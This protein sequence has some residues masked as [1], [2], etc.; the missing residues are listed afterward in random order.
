LYF[1]S[2]QSQHHINA[3]DQSSSCTCLNHGAVSF[4]CLLASYT[5]EVNDF[6]D[7]PMWTGGS[8]ALV[9]KHSLSEELKLLHPWAYDGRG[10][11]TPEMPIR[12]LPFW[13]V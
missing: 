6:L 11:L 7:V 1:P 4:E 10:L 5:E 3:T 13:V 8:G 12:H 2:L 9:S